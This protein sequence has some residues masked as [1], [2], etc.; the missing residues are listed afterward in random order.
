MAYRQTDTIA[1]EAEAVDAIDAAIEESI[2]RSRAETQRSASRSRLIG[3]AGRL[4]FL[5]GLVTFGITWA[6][7]S[8][9]GILV[10][11]MIMFAS[12]GINRNLMG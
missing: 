4:V 12:P 3:W 5:V 11:V 6:L 8:E 10:A 7:D 2:A 9:W 1:A